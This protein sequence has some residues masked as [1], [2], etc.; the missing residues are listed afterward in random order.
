MNDNSFD[1]TKQEDYSKIVDKKRSRRKYVAFKNKSRISW[2]HS[3]IFIVTN[4]DDTKENLDF[5]YFFIT[6]NL[7]V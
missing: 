4:F 3:N 2:I 6:L 7:V 1:I 5:I